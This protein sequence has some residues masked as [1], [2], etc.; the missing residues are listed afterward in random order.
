MI[1][2]CHLEKR[3]LHFFGTEIHAQHSVDADHEFGEKLIIK[4]EDNLLVL[5]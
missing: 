2:Y 1:K 4:L 3:H 5:E